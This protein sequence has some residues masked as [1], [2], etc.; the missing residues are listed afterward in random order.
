MDGN[1]GDIMAQT[2][3]VAQIEAAKGKCDC[4][5]CQLL[6]KGADSASDSLLR[7]NKAIISPS[8]LREAETALLSTR[9][10]E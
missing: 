2:V 9:E 1:R 6:R 8:A 7:S 5:V 3:F 4:K 10:E